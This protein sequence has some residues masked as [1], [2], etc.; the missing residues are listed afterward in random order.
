MSSLRNRIVYS[1]VG[2]VID[3]S[4]SVSVFCCFRA[5]IM[6]GFLSFSFAF[7]ALV[8]SSIWETGYSVTT[9]ALSYELIEDALPFG[10]PF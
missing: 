7:E 5:F 3:Y 10:R 2:V 4:F 9:V 8:G 1:G 6:L